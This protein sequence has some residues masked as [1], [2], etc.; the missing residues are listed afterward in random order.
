MQETVGT[1]MRFGRKKSM[2]ATELQEW[3]QHN[4]RHGAL[5]GGGCGATATT[6][7]TTTTG[8]PLS[9][10]LVTPTTLVKD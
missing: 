7:T 8:S 4:S 9:G 6:T 1:A 3:W 5:S 10:I 2:V